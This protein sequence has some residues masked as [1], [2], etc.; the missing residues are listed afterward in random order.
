MEPKSNFG[1]GLFAPQGPE[2]NTPSSIIVKDNHFYHA[3][4]R[5]M[6]VQQCSTEELGGQIAVQLKPGFYLN[7]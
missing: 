6:Y 5:S 2:V 1:F 3:R 7:A 4:K